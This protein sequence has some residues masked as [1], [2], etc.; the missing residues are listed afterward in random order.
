[1]VV[2]VV[3][4]VG[5]VVMALLD[6]PQ[7][8]SVASELLNALHRHFNPGLEANLATWFSTG[9]L[10]MGALITASVARAKVHAKD[11]LKY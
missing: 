3:F 5:A 11:P 9:L 2:V 8:N 7:S 1:M 10:I 4:A 6:P